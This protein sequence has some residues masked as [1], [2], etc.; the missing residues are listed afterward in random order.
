MNLAIFDTSN[1]LSSTPQ[2]IIQ[3]AF[4]IIQQK[5]GTCWNVSQ[6]NFRKFQ[7]LLENNYLVGSKGFKFLDNFISH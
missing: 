2:E 1:A 6:N 5:W 3:G 7:I 4:P